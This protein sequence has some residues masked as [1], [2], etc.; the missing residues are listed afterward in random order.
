MLIAFSLTKKAKGADDWNGNTLQP[1]SPTHSAIEKYDTVVFF[2]LNPLACNFF[3]LFF[4]TFP[5]PL[6]Q[7][8]AQSKHEE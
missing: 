1:E 4:Q 3:S 5:Q 7:N 2:W 8:P 6:T